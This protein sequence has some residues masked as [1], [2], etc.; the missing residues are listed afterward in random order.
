MA[1]KVELSAGCPNKSRV[2][3]IDVLN[4]LECDLAI[5][6]KGK[7]VN[8]GIKSREEAG[9]PTRARYEEEGNLGGSPGRERNHRMLSKQ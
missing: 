7:K 2:G 6:N 8:R 4:G 1:R 5:I 3:N 9:G